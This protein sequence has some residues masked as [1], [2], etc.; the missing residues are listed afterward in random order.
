VTGPAPDPVD[1]VDPGADTR[2]R[3]AP[4]TVAVSLA[5]IEALV[6]VLL[7]ILE[8]FALTG[9]RV[10]MGLSTTAFFWVY[11][12]GLAFCAWRLAL[13]HS[14]A[15]APVVL[16]QLIQLGVAWSFKD[17]DTVLI[18]VALAV[19]AVIVIAGVMHP[20]SIAALAADE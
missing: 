20:R 2:G 10:T 17:G 11:G 19:V 9:D 7:G 12:V 6:L 1:P 4:L 14:W 13:L 8:L 15:R 18:A 16:A 3:P 5:G